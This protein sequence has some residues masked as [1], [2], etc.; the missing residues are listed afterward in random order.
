MLL[1]SPVIIKATVQMMAD[2]HNIILGKGEL[3]MHWD[4]RFS[5]QPRKAATPQ[6]N[7]ETAIR[8][9]ENSRT[10]HEEIKSLGVLERAYSA[11]FI[12]TA[13]DCNDRLRENHIDLRNKLMNQFQEA[14]QKRKKGMISKYQLASELRTLCKAA[15]RGK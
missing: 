9:Y 14:V 4:T 3:F 6:E 15:V 11:V 10:L 2:S 1:G 12:F 5:G 8:L 13:R 7:I